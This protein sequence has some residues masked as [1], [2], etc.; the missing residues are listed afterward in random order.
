LSMLLESSGPG[1]AG[2]NKIDSM[3]NRKEG[4][5][6]VPLKLEK[7]TIRDNVDLK[8]KQIQFIQPRANK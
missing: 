7:K 5:A 1:G 4:V 2:K 3:G 8:E 6:S